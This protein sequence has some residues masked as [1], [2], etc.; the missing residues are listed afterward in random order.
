MGTQ[1]PISEEK[2]EGDVQALA[3]LME[4][5]E[6]RLLYWLRII[7]DEVLIRSNYHVYLAHSKKVNPDIRRVESA[8]LKARNE[9]QKL[10][11]EDRQLLDVTMREITPWL[12]IGRKEFV[13]YDTTQFDVLFSVM[14]ETFVALTG[15]DVRHKKGEVKDWRLAAFATMLLHW[16]QLHGGKPVPFDHK[17]VGGGT[18]FQEAWK[19]LRRIG[20]S[21]ILPAKIPL[22]TIKR[23]KERGPFGVS[24]FKN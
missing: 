16:P 10:R 11:K 9:F 2:F 22:S 3:D 20:Y 24:D 18:K 4:V 19:L 15:R 13:T 12:Q 7:N 14:V 23:I 1:G 8:I 17:L 21:N 6:D 5:Q